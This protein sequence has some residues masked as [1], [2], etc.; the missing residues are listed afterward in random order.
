MCAK[1]LQYQAP[2]NSFGTVQAA[3]G[4]Q[5]L[6]QA[7]TS[8]APMPGIPEGST[9][10]CCRPDAAAAGS[11]LE[12]SVLH[13][14]SAHGMK[15]RRRLQPHLVVLL[16]TAAATPGLI[17]DTLYHDA[18]AGSALLHVKLMQCNMG[19]RWC[20]QTATCDLPSSAP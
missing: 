11:R 16:C 20:E 1:A 19:G 2:A 8:D 17:P 6:S 15:E 5:L 13:Y 10:R 12:N 4:L 18:A 7:V 9:V 3:G 14:M